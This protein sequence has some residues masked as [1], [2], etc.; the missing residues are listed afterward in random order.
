MLLGAYPARRQY[1]SSLIY[2]QASVHGSDGHCAKLAGAMTTSITAPC[3]NTERSLKSAYVY[4]DRIFARNM[5]LQNTHTLSSCS[6]V[7]V[8]CFIYWYVMKLVYCTGKLSQE[9]RQ[10]P[11][12]MQSPQAT[13]RQPNP[14]ASPGSLEARSCTQLDK[15]LGVAILPVHPNQLEV[16]LSCDPDPARTSPSCT[17]THINAVT[18]DV[19]MWVLPLSN[20]TTCSEST[21]DKGRDSD[22]AA[23]SVR[24]GADTDHP[25]KALCD[26]SQALLLQVLSSKRPAVCF[27]SQGMSA[28]PDSKILA[29]RCLNLFVIA[30]H[31]AP[32]LSGLRP[33][34]YMI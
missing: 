33:S 1:G 31:L 19:T 22:K 7:L 16:L 25:S 4:G 32:C 23:S 10:L 12:T 3:S 30:L 6:C 24:D 28:C 21:H 13:E 5:M 18:G 2:A 34:M 17:D 11:P 8:L 27:D 26:N 15:V 9:Y 20:L 29:P 14:T